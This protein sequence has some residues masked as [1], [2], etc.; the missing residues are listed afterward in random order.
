MKYKPSIPKDNMYKVIERLTTKVEEL[1]SNMERMRLAEYIK[2]LENPGRLVYTN[3]LI[4]LARGF[5]AA[6]GFTLLA[7]V[8]I[9]VLQKF[10]LL[11]LPILGE[12]IASLVAIVQSQL[13]VGGY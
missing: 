10:M 5:G 6:I 8:V 1:S 11:N 13:N 2:M 3:F 7:A 4:G 9:Y 12:F